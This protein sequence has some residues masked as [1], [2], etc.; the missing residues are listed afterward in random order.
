[1]VGVCCPCIPGSTAL[2]G[3]LGH[4]WPTRPSGPTLAGC[5]CPRRFLLWT[6]MKRPWR[7]VLGVV[8]PVTSL[9]ALFERKNTSTE[10]AR[11]ICSPI[12]RGLRKKR[13][14]ANDLGDYRVR[15]AKE[16]GVVLRRC[17]GLSYGVIGRIEL[18]CLQRQNREP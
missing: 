8:L 9:N 15:E 3:C 1:M 10:R 7:R 18:S 5:H 6:A 13:A 4:S 14:A 17:P 2:I 12:A 16:V 11:S